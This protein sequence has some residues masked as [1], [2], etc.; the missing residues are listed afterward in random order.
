MEDNRQG[1]QEDFEVGWIKEAC[2]RSNDPWPERQDKKKQLSK[3]IL[4]VLAV[5]FSLGRFHKSILIHLF[6]SVTFC[7]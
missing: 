1:R 4:G 7:G 2:V 6:P 3:I 5:F